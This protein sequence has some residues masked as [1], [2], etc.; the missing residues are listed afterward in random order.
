M[1]TESVLQKMKLTPH[2]VAGQIRFEGSSWTNWGAVCGLGFGIVAPIV[3][4]LLT[5]IAWFTGSEWHGLH[6]HRTGTVLFV[7]TIPLLAFGAHC[8]DLS[9][10]QAN[11]ANKEAREARQR[12]ST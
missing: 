10:R 5:I 6:L 2:A 12:R 7:L 11:Q 3:G 9:D 1:T 8:L 4:M